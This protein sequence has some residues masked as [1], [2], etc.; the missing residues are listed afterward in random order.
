MQRAMP[1]RILD[2]LVGLVAAAAVAATVVIT[3]TAVF[4]RYVLNDSLPWPEEIDGYL[5]IWISFL[6]AY[7]AARDGQHLGVDIVVDLLPPGGRRVLRSVLDLGLIGLFGLVLFYSLRWISISGG[8]EIMTLE[9]SK[10]FF[11]VAIPISMVL[12]MLAT[13]VTLVRRWTRP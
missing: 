12:L 5:L 9:I 10:G 6:G 7:L 2:R 11:M 1:L 13:A 8:R 3:C 4:F